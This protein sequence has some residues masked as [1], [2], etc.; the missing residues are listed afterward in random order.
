MNQIYVP[1]ADFEDVT[2]FILERVPEKARM[3][4]KQ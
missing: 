4:S 1:K 2:A 3:R